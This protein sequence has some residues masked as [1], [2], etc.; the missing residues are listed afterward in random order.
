MYSET[1]DFT[2]TGGRCANDAYS[3]SAISALRK[4]HTKKRPAADDVICGARNAVQKTGTHVITKN[5]NSYRTLRII[6]KTNV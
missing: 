5:I 2:K 6:I 1:S 3:V 4:I